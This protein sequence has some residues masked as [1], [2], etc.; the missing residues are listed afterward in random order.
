MIRIERARSAGNR[1]LRESLYSGVIHQRNATSASLELVEHVQQLLDEALDGDRRGASTRLDEPSFFDR[2]GKIRRVLYTETHYHDAI[3]RLL[4]AGGFDPASVAF[5]PLRLRVVSHR[6][7]EN[8]RAH[9]VY[10]AHRDTWYAHPQNLITWWIPLDNLDAHETF[11]FYPERFDRPVPNDSEA[12]DYAS[13]VE[14]DWKLKIG[15]QDRDSGLSAHYPGVPGLAAAID[16]GRELGFACR[17]GENLL[18]SGAH[19]H[20]TL[21]QATG[22]TR[23]SLDL[24][25]VHLGDHAEGL[26]APNVDNQSQGSA[27]V[28]YIR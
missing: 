16:A 11:V 2:I 1:A 28:D 7:H 12:F 26:G 13:W 4:A 14:Q 3:R 21:P 22:R 23:Y 20:R 8:P 15:W 25:L 24:R 27:L 19:Y 18:F 6:G 17:R 5:D 9:S 10:L